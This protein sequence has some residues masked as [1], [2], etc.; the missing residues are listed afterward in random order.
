MTQRLDRLTDR[1]QDDYIRHLLRQAGGKDNP[2][3]EYTEASIERLAERVLALEKRAEE[4][5][6]G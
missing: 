2:L 6:R 4:A 1:I 5:G 3:R